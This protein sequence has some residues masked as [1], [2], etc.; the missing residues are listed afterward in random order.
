VAYAEADLGI[1]RPFVAFVWGSGDGDPTDNKL[2]GFSP[3]ANQD[4]TQI[5]GTNWFAH[6]DTSANF[7]GRDYAC[8]ARLQGVRTAANAATGPLAIGTRVF[9]SST[10]F[11]CSHTVANPFNQRLGNQS[12]LGIFSTYSNP[13]TLVIAPGLKVY[14]LKGYELVGWYV[15]RGMVTTN[16]LE[17]AF[18]AGTDPGFTGRIRTSQIHELG[19]YV[20]WTLN[21]YFD[22]RLAGQVAFLG[23]GF[24]DLARLADCDQQTPGFQACVGKDVA[25]KADLRFRARF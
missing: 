5:T 4:V 15:Y 21:P 10:G 11:E 7:A 19:G 17:R 23:E 18:V 12:H 8:P 24:K 25:L 2:H 9:T 13:G 22:I 1:V 16:L 3:A 20:M 6:L 14:P